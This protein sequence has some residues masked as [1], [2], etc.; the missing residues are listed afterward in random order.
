MKF[1]NYVYT[2]RIESGNQY[3]VLK[4]SKHKEKLIIIEKN[5][6]GIQLR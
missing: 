6:I 3:M 5:V 4:Y 2:Y 1:L